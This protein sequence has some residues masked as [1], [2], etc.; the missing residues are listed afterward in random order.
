MISIGD[1]VILETVDSLHQWEGYISYCVD[2][3]FFN[4]FS[5]ESYHELDGWNNVAM[6]VCNRGEAP[7]LCMFS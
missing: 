5:K 1:T 6:C 4:D 3:M 2:S 7:G